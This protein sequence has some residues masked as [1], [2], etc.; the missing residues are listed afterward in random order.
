MNSLIWA[1]VLIAG[2]YLLFKKVILPIH[3]KGQN[4]AA[5][6][7]KNFGPWGALAGETAKLTGYKGVSGQEESSSAG[8]MSSIQGIFKKS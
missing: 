3:N 8:L 5:S 2:L 7:G 6:Y 4:F 1:I